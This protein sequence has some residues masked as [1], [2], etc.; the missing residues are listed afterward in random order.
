MV[1]PCLELW[2]SYRCSN[3]WLLITCHSL[4]WGC[5]EKTLPK[6]TK[7][8]KE[9]IWTYSFCS[10][11]GESHGRWMRQKPCRGHRGLCAHRQAL[12]EPGMLSIQSCHLP[13]R[14]GENWFLTWWRLCFLCSLRLHWT[15]PQVLI[16]NLFFSVILQSPSLWKVIGVLYTEFWRRPHLIFIF[17]EEIYVCFLVCVNWVDYQWESFQQIVLR[18]PKINHLELDSWNLNKN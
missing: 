2:L 5:C 11:P 14:L 3:Y 7:R 10:I 15:L 13:R 17:L 8:S 1:H 4:L 12:E 6:A 16:I 18:T 9:S